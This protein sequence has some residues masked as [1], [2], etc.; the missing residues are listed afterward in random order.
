[1]NF[2]I[3]LLIATTPLVPPSIGGPVPSHP[4]IP[5]NEI[6]LTEIE[7]YLNNVINSR[8][9]SPIEEI[10]EDFGSSCDSFYGSGLHY[11]GIK[12]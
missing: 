10:L 9:R 6:K 3:S 2:L 7:V 4:P 8:E 1:M 5:S 12:W 11:P